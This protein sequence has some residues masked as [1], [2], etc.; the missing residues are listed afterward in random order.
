MIGKGKGKKIRRYRVH[1]FLERMKT[2]DGRNVI[3]R[4]KLKKRKALTVSDKRKVKKSG[5]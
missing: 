4:R 2:Q 3:K 1:G 5:K